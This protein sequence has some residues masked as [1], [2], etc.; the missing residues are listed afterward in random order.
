MK[1][2]APR[3]RT[4]EIAALLLALRGVLFISTTPQGAEARAG[5]GDL[6]LGVSHAPCVRLFH[7]GGDVGCRTP[8][9]EGVA[10]PLLLVDSG[11]A[12]RD[13]EAFGAE[14]THEDEDTRG[15]EGGD[16]SASGAP[17]PVEGIGDGLITVVPAAFLNSSTLDRLSA[18]GLL[19]GVLVLED[20]GTGVAETV[21]GEA[22]RGGPG[23]SVLAS[24]GGLG[25][26]GGVAS[27]PDVKTPQGE[28]TP[29]AAFDV[30]AS[31]PWNPL[32][33]GLLMEALDFPVV[34]V[35]G[36]SVAE[37][38]ARSVSN[39]PLG[40]SS[41]RYPL[42][43]ARMTF[44]FGGSGADLNSQKCLGW[45][46][47][48]GGRSPQCKPLGGQSSW[49]S[50]GDA[51]EG[52]RQTVFA[53]AG[54]DSTAMFHDRAPGANSA[55][56][57]LVALLCAAESLGATGRSGGVDFS[58]LPR[59]IVFAAFQ[60]EAF[61]FTGSRRFLQD[62]RGSGVSC[63]NKADPRVSPSGMEACLDPL[64]PSLE[65]QRLERPAHVLAVDQV[66]CLPESKL[67]VHP[68]S[69]ASAAELGVVSSLSP[70]G[71]GGVV[72]ANSSKPE[73][74][75]SP[76]T[77]FVKADPQQSGFVISGYDE[78]FSCPHYHSHLDTRDRVNAT[79][80]AAAAEVLAKS[81]LVL[82]GGTEA[83]AKTL[84]VNA[85]LVE[86][87]LDCLVE[88]WS[89]DTV[90]EYV[91]GELG[92]LEEVLGFRV[93]VD[94]PF[95][96]TMYT[97]PLEF[98]NGGG[99]PTVR[100]TKDDGSWRLH[101]S[102]TESFDP[103]HDKI[104][105][106]PSLVEIFCRAF[107][108]EQ[109]GSAHAGRYG[110]TECNSSGDCPQEECEETHASLDGTGRRPECV[111]GR[112]GCPTGFHHIALGVGL[113]REQQLDQYRVVDGAVEQGAPL[114]TEP[115]WRGI[116]VEV[117][118]DPG[119]AAGNIAVVVGAAVTAAAGVASW[120]LL[121]SLEKRKL[122][123]A[124]ALEL[125]EALLCSG[126][127]EFE[128]IWSGEVLVTST[129]FVSNGT[130]L[131]ITSSS[132]STSL[133]FTSGGAA[134][135]S[136]AVIDG[137]DEVQ[138]FVVDAI[139]SLELNGLSLQRGLAGAGAVEVMD[140][141]L[142]T[143]VDCSFSYNGVAISV[144]GFG[145]VSIEGESVFEYNSGDGIYVN[146]GYLFVDGE[147]S[148]VGNQGA[149]WIWPFSSTGSI[150]GKTTFSDNNNTGSSGGAL[151]I[152]YSEVTIEGE[153]SFTNNTGS[154]GGAIYMLGGALRVD[155]ISSFM[156]NVAEQD[157]GG[158]GFYGEEGA[159]VVFDGTTRFEGNHQGAVYASFSEATVLGTTSFVGNTRTGD[160]GAVYNF[161]GNFST[162]GNT[163]FAD[164]TADGLGL[165]GALYT[166]L[167]NLSLE[168]LTHWTG[169]EA[170]GDGG[171]VYVSQMDASIGEGS[172]FFSRNSAGGNG[173]AIAVADAS[174]LT[175]GNATTFVENTA[176]SNGGAVYVVDSTFATEQETFFDGNTAVLGAGGGIYCSTAVA[177]F[178]GSSFTEN[179]AIW[180]GGL[181]LFSSGS[182]LTDEME[183]DDPV[184]TSTVGC[185]FKGNTADDGGAMYSAA[186]YD[187]IEDSS[188]ETNFAALSGGGF[189]HSGVLVELRNTNFFNN[190]AGEDG[191]A[192]MSL[193]IAENFFNVTFKA[194]TFYCPPGEYGHDVDQSDDEVSG[195]CRFEVVCSRCAASCDGSEVLIDNADIDPSVVP[196]CRG[197]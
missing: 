5:T 14:R 19:G 154:R 114:W 48:A 18:T 59:Q 185:A 43:K 12:L 160:G 189:L 9:R 6:S 57:G 28:S 135:G 79:S 74:P 86:T 83:Q 88:D 125:S 69:G 127:G 47:I 197:E 46:D 131:K 15:S 111:R 180:G 97:G 38:L 183:A 10:G 175:I 21:V 153:T 162:E 149:I 167:S 152:A 35:T 96:P 51:G 182:V 168:G 187:I 158:G 40:G 110:E 98:R 66:G 173:G 146:E 75:P 188:F 141:S 193:G 176:G 192:I 41:W 3:T 139:S 145:T 49:A 92:N 171:A 178:N 91:V 30:D 130:S 50:V 16:A 121:R 2:R 72:L 136:Q 132:S 45:T 65:F 73:L 143:A 115:N 177:K 124:E 100:H 119:V 11:K 163:T 120:V 13:V 138:L 140:S 87:L 89:C 118:L 151:H 82:A 39:G 169:N 194:N 165:G 90:K 80:V 103:D 179:S 137:G 161:M 150:A 112:C 52:G 68:S 44:Y 184:P 53:V 31:Y 64:Y 117:Y 17:E 76:L 22:S 196:V 8:G 24:A 27:N 94:A 56:S 126:A 99:M 181:A 20:D 157:G 61:G 25:G 147:T 36:P 93:S 67:W 81:T 170:G 155:G 116:G 166:R 191:L 78:S 174:S 164:N 77:A 34:L 33:D 128:A 29:S 106:V 129:I 102:W 134:T 109:L 71:D 159:S 26:A 55:V 60:G 42:H 133:V 142:L 84:E 63:Q 144:S 32:G 107:L 95:P 104:Q 62:W 54:M 122:F 58:A 4:A 148:F 105:L 101:S 123:T 1:L 113:E 23:V 190:T 85:T 186:G 108:S 195:T 156:N 70:G 172:A 7:S 37:V